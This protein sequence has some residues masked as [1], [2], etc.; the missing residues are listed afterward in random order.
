MLLPGCKIGDPPDWSLGFE[1]MA[2]LHINR[3]TNNLLA[4]GPYVD[5]LA[6]FA[7]ASLQ[8]DLVTETR[9]AIG[10]AS[11]VVLPQ[12]D[13][14]RA[15]ERALKALQEYV[16]TGGGEATADV[17]AG[18]LYELL[19]TNGFSETRLIDRQPF[20]QFFAALTASTQNQPR[21]GAHAFSYGLASTF[22]G[23]CAP[24]LRAWG[25]PVVR[26][27]GG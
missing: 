6:Q 19:N 3:A 7:A 21:A 2:R 17:V 8:Y 14:I 13:V 26:G 25:L 20:V 27:M 1:S 12:E 24:Q 15:R 5:G 10:S 16:R 9:D 11:A 23:G 4:G 18:M 22:G